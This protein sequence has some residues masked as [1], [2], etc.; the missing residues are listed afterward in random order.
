MTARKQVSVSGKRKTAVARANAVKGTGKIR[1]NKVP[2]EI[3][4]PELARTKMME[5]V[6]IAG[7][8]AAKMNIE[9]SVAGG[10]IMGQAEAVRAALANAIVDFLE[11]DELKHKYLAYDRSILINDVRF[12][13][14]KHFGGRGARKRQQKS[15]R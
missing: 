11:D 4:V 6:V 2:I 3:V 7:E 15:Y 12:K 14:P 5:P 9:V 10:G 13:E 8:K 1:V